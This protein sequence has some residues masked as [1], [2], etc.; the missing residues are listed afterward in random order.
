MKKNSFFIFAIFLLPV[1]SCTEK[2]AADDAA[3][4]VFFTRRIVNTQALG[5]ELTNKINQKVFEAVLNGK[6]KAYKM[7]SLTTWSV[8]SIPD[9]KDRMNKKETLTIT[10]DPTYPEYTI[11]ST[12]ITEFK[13]ENITGHSISEKW[14]MDLSKT[15]INAELHAFGLNW[16]PVFANIELGEQALFWI[17]FN[18]LE[19][20][21]SKEEM[22]S[23]NKLLHKERFKKIS[24]Y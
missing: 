3:A 1:L 22:K 24:D 5:T 2:K 13:T 14:S 7:D 21:L 12:I 19:K 18:D 16:K 11:D 10:P 20:F 15:I 8:F 23:L 6:I 4:N 9:L 17:P